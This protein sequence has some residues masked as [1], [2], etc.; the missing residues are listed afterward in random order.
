MK[1]AIIE[2]IT[3]SAVSVMATLSLVYMLDH[4]IHTD[5]LM[6]LLAF[7]VWVVSGTALL[8]MWAGAKTDESNKKTCN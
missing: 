4:D 1:N 8:V 2:I 6:C 5:T 7:L 3:A